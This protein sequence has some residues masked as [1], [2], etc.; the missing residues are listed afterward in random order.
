MNIRWAENPQTRCWH[1]TIRERQGG[2]GSREVRGLSSDLPTPAKNPPTVS[3]IQ[4]YI[5]CFLSR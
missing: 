1:R 2:G 3:R 5:A 4:A